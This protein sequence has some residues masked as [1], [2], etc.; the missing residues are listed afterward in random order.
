MLNQNTKNPLNAK[1]NVSIKITTL[2]I[3]N[4]TIFDGKTKKKSENLMQLHYR[5]SEHSINQQQKKQQTSQSSIRS[6]RAS[7][8]LKD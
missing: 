6:D 8:F 7:T 5:T 1:N 2:K 3:N 4:F